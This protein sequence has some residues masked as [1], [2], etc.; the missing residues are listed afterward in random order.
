LI[1]GSGLAGLRA[2]IAAA[3]NGVS[4]TVVS[5]SSIGA[6]CNSIL[7][8]GGFA[9][10]VSGV[11]AEKHT[12]ATLMAGQY[13]NDRELVRKL[14]A[15]GVQ[16]ADFL[17]E[18]GVD[19]SP[20]PFGCRVDR[21]ANT[22]AGKIT[23]GQILM[24][25]MTEAARRQEQIR[26]VPYFF[27]YKILLS[28]DR[29]SGVIGFE[30]DGSH[31]LISCKAII[32][33]TGGGAGVYARNDNCRG[34][35]GDGYT[36]AM[37][38]GISLTDMEF[39]QFYPLGFAEPKLPQ[40]IIYPPIPPEAR[41][42]DAQGIDFLE[43]YRIAMD[44]HNFIMTARD[45]A[46]YLIYQD[47]QRDGVFLDYTGVPDDLWDAYPLSLFPTQ[48]F[49]FRKKPFRIS[50]VAH[51]FM[52]GIKTG[53]AGETDVP[54]LF[55]AGEVTAG[56]HGANRLGGNALTECLVF[57]AESGFSAAEY[58]KSRPLER[59]AFN[60]EQWLIALL[61]GKPN[62]KARTDL[63]ATLRKIRDIAWTYAGPVRN[64]TGIK[65]GLS[66]LEEMAG[67]LNRVEVNNTIELVSKKE[68]ANSLLVTKAVL[69]ASLARQESI[70]AFQRNDYQQRS[71][72]ASFKRIF[73]RFGGE[74]EALKIY[75]KYEPLNL[76]E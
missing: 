43:K 42:Y 28:G 44:L 29:V 73:V 64:E 68:T 41:I 76:E 37:D 32:L 7:A 16:E 48:R 9:M 14:V 72:S 25:K 31:C 10:A 53:V 5:K 27:V 56:V 61:H 18:V 1:V 12:K 13:V 46:S 38:V 63:S 57:G 69:L 65:K 71:A 21:V 58:A 59:T 24:R 60:G 54:G 23:G 50:P 39:V 34:I 49:S 47:S 67:A 8:G 3:R 22:S 55:A 20:Q 33:A 45:R 62:A 74:D 36:L 17:Q 52:G 19:V 15:S 66:L 2:A 26:L 70:G 4:T 6:G 35:L 11:T 30:K 40:T 51:F 75:E